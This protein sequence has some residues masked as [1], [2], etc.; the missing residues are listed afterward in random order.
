[1]GYWGTGVLVAVPGFGHFLFRLELSNI[2]ANGNY[3][4]ELTRITSG[5]S[6]QD[7]VGSSRTAKAVG[8]VKDEKRR[9]A[10]NAI[11]I[12]GFCIL[13]GGFANCCSPLSELD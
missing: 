7:M 6:V 2:S 1:L 3:T 5:G 8:I 4:G 12:R 9:V 13:K 10:A 11:I